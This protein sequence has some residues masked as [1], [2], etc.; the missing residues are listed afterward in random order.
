MTTPNYRQYGSGPEFDF[1]GAGRGLALGQLN[2]PNGPAPSGVQYFS[3]P[4][5]T[6]PATQAPFNDGAGGP[7][8]S[9]TAGSEADA[10]GVEGL[11][12]GKQ[13][14]VNAA[15]TVGGLALGPVGGMAVSGIADAIG[16]NSFS[17]AV[18]SHT[19]LDMKDAIAANVVGP[20]AGLFGFETATQQAQRQ[21]DK[22]Q[23]E[24]DDMLRDR[25]GP[26][27]NAT[28][29]A[30]P[31][32]NPSDPSTGNF[33]GPAGHSDP[34]T[35]P[36]AP[37]SSQDRDAPSM[38]PPEGRDGTGG[39]AGTRVIC[40]ELH[41]QGLLSRED[42][43]R[44]LDF[45]RRALTATHVRGYHAWAIP[46]VRWMKRNE[47][48]CRIIRAVAQARANEIAYL[49]G[50]RDRSDLLG[51]IIRYTCEPLCWLIG[52]LIEIKESGDARARS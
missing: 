47:L 19:N 32:S 39:G 52:R 20:L 42:W 10:G 31:T 3:R 34:S 46:T 9:S 18:Q 35:A 7:D 21:K 45:T 24:V 11:G 25:H 27:A 38:G 51:R 16:F 36:G 44:D 28:A 41:R 14:A 13:D 50:N 6:V 23:R 40:T 33:G 49:T 48:L 30:D 22:M 43:L 4:V 12:I 29:D 37:S 2:T 26:N 5:A 8:G 17:P 15:G 1:F